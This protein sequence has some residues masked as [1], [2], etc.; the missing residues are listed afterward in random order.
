MKTNQIFVQRRWMNV[1]ISATRQKQAVICVCSL[2]GILI[3]IDP[4]LAASFDTGLNIR[5]A[6]EPFTFSVYEKK[7]RSA[8]VRALQRSASHQNP[9]DQV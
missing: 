7:A 6:S 8:S 1:N 9:L 5:R 3:T 2:R 4:R